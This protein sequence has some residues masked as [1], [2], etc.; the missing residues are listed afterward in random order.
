MRQAAESFLGVLKADATLIGCVMQ[1]SPSCT[2]V[3]KEYLVAN[4]YLSTTGAT[5]KTEQSL[6]AKEPQRARG[7]AEAGKTEESPKAEFD[8]REPVTFDSPMASSVEFLQWVL[9]VINCQIFSKNNLRGLLRKGQRRHARQ[10]LLELLEF[11]SGTEPH[12]VW[13]CFGSN[14]DLCDALVKATQAR[15]N[16][17]QVQIPMNWKVD[18]VYKLER[19]C[20]GELVLAHV[21][22]VGAGQLRQVTL[23][24]AIMGKA[25]AGQLGNLSLETNW[26]ERRAYLVADSSTRCVVCQEVFF[27]AGQVPLKLPGLTDGPVEESPSPPSLTTPCKRPTAS[28]AGSGSTVQT[29]PPTPGTPAPESDGGSHGLRHGLTK[30]LADLIVED[31]PPATPEREAACSAQLELAFDCSALIM[32]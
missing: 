20:N 23:T 1:E 16:I 9:A 13:K 6:A 17:S 22:G 32:L 3:L 25:F 26:S 31:V 14:G 27:Q 2:P 28:T 11:V 21:F 7:Q 4:G 12:A 5:L 30:D 18:G 29:G 8:V 15:S 10:P 24:E 19:G